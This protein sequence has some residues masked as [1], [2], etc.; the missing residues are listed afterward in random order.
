MDSE[1]EVIIV[2]DIIATNGLNGHSEDLSEMK[3]RS[4]TNEGDVMKSKMRSARSVVGGQDKAG[5]DT[6]KKDK[7][8][9][10]SKPAAKDAAATTTTTVKSASQQDKTANV[11]KKSAKVMDEQQQQPVVLLSGKKKNSDREDDSGINSRASSVSNDDSAPRMR[12]RSSRSSDIASTSTPA[13]KGPGRMPLS[14]Y[15]FEDLTFDDDVSSP[16]SL[17][18]KAVLYVEEM[19]DADEEEK[20]TDSEPAAKRPALVA[21]TNFFN[22]FLNPLRALR[23]KFSFRTASEDA[24]PATEE[25]TSQQTSNAA[26]VDAVDTAKENVSQPQTSQDDSESTNESQTCRIM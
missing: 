24:T 12:T 6:E 3:T 21:S 11:T 26:K 17:K 14:T 16:S 4:K 23:G 10:E 7:K 19:E 18:R 22:A 1:N 8:V 20:Q 5:S 9:T 25:T 13:K 15:D 2:D